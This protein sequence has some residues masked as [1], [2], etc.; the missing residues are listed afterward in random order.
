MASTQDMV[1]NVS[2]FIAF[3][4]SV[5]TLEPGDLIFTG[6]PAGVSPLRP[7][8]V[9]EVKIERLGSSAQPCRCRDLTRL[10]RMKQSEPGYPHRRPDRG[11]SC[12]SP[13]RILLSGL[14]VRA[15]RKART[16]KFFR[17]RRDRMVSGWRMLFAAF[18]L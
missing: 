5:M 6:T 11:S 14:G 12:R 4:S 3:I 2:Q 16:L 13:L 10:I 17:M 15:I 1:F 9:V 7:G 8:D 18:V